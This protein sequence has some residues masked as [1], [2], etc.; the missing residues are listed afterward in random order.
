MNK[1]VIVYGGD[2]VEHEISII[3][4]LQAYHYYQGDKY[5]F[6]LVYLAK[7][8][9][10]YTGDKLKDIK[11]YQ[12]MDTLLSSCQ[13]ITFHK[14]KNESYYRST[15]KKTS[16]DYV[17]LI[18]HGL[19]CEDGTLYNYFQVKDILCIGLDQYQGSIS[20]DKYLCKQYLKA[21]KIKQVPFTS[22]YYNEFLD[23]PQVILKKVKHLGFP[24][25]VKPAKLG[26]S[27]GVCVIEDEDKLFEALE[28]GFLYDQLLIVEKYLQNMREFNIAMLGD[29][30]KYSLSLIE[31][32]SRHHALS[33]DDKYKNSDKTK[34][35]A[36][37]NRKIPA[38]ISADLER[39][40]KD[41]AYK[42][43][44]ALNTALLVRLDFLYDEENQEIYFNEIN[45]IPGSLAFY[46]WEPLQ[47]SF[48][49][50]IENVMRIGI[51][52]EYLKR[53]LLSQYKENIL[54]GNQLKGIKIQK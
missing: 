3:T 23:N 5:I 17:W 44:S 32:V 18:V 22:V 30:E 43:G 39:Q 24:V 36:G 37:L 1:V 49:Q 50:L 53:S 12:N 35:M 40:I 19:H 16:F 9:H 48:S 14:N 33:Y 27:V 28:N 4:A 26:S 38:D 25:I 29:R 21:F 15:F 47:I 54:N 10:F 6:E 46:L 41:I 34:G 2:S 11:N 51:K 31:E 8:K 45:N 52:N 20:Q 7:D 13:K 42:V